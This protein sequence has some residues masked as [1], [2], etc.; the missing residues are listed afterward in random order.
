MNSPSSYRH[1]TP[2]KHPR[3]I[4]FQS[5]QEC[6]ETYLKKFHFPLRHVARDNFVS[7][8][9][10]LGNK[11][12]WTRVF[13]EGTE[14]TPFF[15]KEHGFTASLSKKERRRRNK[16]LNQFKT[17][18]TGANATFKSPCRRIAF[19][20]NTNTT[21]LPTTNMF[22]TIPTT[23]TT[24]TTALLASSEPDQTTT[25]QLLSATTKSMAALP[26]L[27]T[28]SSVPTASMPSSHTQTNVHTSNYQQCSPPAEQ[29]STLPETIAASAA[30][31]ARN[32]NLPVHIQPS[33]LSISSPSPAELSTPP[34]PALAQSYPNDSYDYS[35]A[36]LA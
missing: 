30:V 1:A 16:I 27:P 7:T 6:I 35:F 26:D 33:Q 23:A 4:P 28:W 12:L 13:H 34:L 15:S 11:H 21:I 29:S 8:L 36:N 32:S 14:A 3:R 9:D 20:R 19:D 24:S 10:E 2:D 5:L 22:T 25:S 31:A 18:A 17:P